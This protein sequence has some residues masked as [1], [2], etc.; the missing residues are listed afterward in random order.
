[1]VKEKTTEKKSVKLK[2]V[3]S[4][5]TIRAVGRRKEAIA[6]VRLQQGTGVFVINEMD[7]KEYFPYTELQRVAESA[8]S[9]V[10]LRT[11]FDISVKIEGGGI[12]GQAESVRHGITR[13]LVTYNPELKKTLRGAGFVTRDPRV[14]ERKKPG[15]KR[16]RRAPQF[17]KR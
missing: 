6:R 14:K 17:S 1:M 5:T 7:Y 4:D 8:L 10:N 2:Q 16:A 13:C 11:T 3:E 9:L 12:R 15:L